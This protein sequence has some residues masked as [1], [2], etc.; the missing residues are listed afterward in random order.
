MADKQT[1]YRG[2]GWKR[3]WP[4]PDTL[5]LFFLETKKHH[6]TL[7]KTYVSAEIRVKHLANISEILNLD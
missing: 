7:T 2:F 1:D 3:S 6:E 5:L 4:N